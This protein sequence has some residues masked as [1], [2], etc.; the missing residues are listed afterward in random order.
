MKIAIIGFALSGATFLQTILDNDP[1]DLKIYIYE[2]RNEYPTGLPYEKDSLDKLLN[3]DTD[4]MVYPEDMADDFPKWMDAN[5]KNLDPVENM[6]PRVYF[7][8][9]LKEKTKDYLNNPCVNL[10]NEE[11]K[12]I[13]VEIIASKE[14]YTVESATKKAKYDLVFLGTGAS[15][16]QDTYILER[17]ENYIAKT[18]PHEEKHK[19]ITEDKK[20]AIH[21]STHY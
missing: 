8:Q 21:I 15:F 20:H 13:S 16:Y 19:D 9:Y 11:V 7:G 18:Y 6:A 2:K 1:T 10:I 5:N 4:E 3:V 17:M 14:R 12:N